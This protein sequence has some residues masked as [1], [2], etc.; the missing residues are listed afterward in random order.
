M[1][2]DSDLKACQYHRIVLDEAQSIK[3]PNGGPLKRLTG[4]K[5]KRRWCVTGATI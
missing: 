3:N 4:F 5:A 1:L 2:A